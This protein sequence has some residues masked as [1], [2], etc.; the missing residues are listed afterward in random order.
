MNSKSVFSKEQLQQVAKEK[1]WIK[2]FLKPGVKVD[3]QLPAGDI[4]F[5]H[6]KESLTFTE[7]GDDMSHISIGYDDGKKEKKR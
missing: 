6:K 7:Y 3:I 4:T 2:R 1:K 5:T